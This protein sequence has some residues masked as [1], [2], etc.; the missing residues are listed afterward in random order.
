MKKIVIDPGHGGIDGG[1]SKNGILEKDYTLK[2]S[3]YMKDRFEKLGI[4]VSITRDDD[5]TLDPSNRVKKIK[6]FY[7]DGNDVIVISNHINAGGGDG[8]EII[9]SLR[10]NDNLSK[11]IK[12]E[13]ERTNQNFRKYYQRSLPSN[14]KKDYYYILRDT[15]NNE[16]II[17][18]YGFVDSK[19]D[20]VNIIKNNWKE[21][22]EA[23]VKGVS[24]YI[25]IP[26]KAN[27]ESN[28][29]QVKKGD[30][31][32]S[33]SNKYGVKI[34]D[35]KEFNNL[36]SN[37]LSIGEILYI[38]NNDIKDILI[39]EYIV[40]KGDTLYSISK[41][42]K[43]SIDELKRINNLNSDILSIGQ[44]LIINNYNNE[45]IYEVKKG[46]TLYSISN[47]YGVDVNTLKQINNKDSNFLSIGEKIK[48][49]ILSN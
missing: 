12:K 18:E 33:I 11:I 2:I 13:I 39:Q 34:N 16:S 21:L 35:I 29:Y 49:P 10:N 25:G 7:G 27:N 36:N 15:P 45:I 48:I 3:K 46:D 43:I 42:F 24:E 31:L 19:G 41:R 8:L 26:Y 30:T 38:P 23:V 14:P 28:Y 22:A 20:D 9:Y 5:I 6:S 44:K 4:P 17:I 37:L 47:K 32:Y 1:A 40:E